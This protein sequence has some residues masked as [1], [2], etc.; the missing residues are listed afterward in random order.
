M[1]QSE[2]HHHNYSSPKATTL[3]NCRKYGFDSPDKSEESAFFQEESIYRQLLSEQS[4]IKKP[5]YIEESWLQGPEKQLRGLNQKPTGHPIRSDQLQH[6]AN[7]SASGCRNPVSCNPR[8][9]RRKINIVPSLKLYGF[10]SFALVI[11]LG[12][13]TKKVGQ[14]Y[15]IHRSLSVDGMTSDH[16][17]SSPQ[18]VDNHRLLTLRSFSPIYWLKEK[19]SRIHM[20]QKEEKISPR[21]TEELVIE[22]QRKSSI[23][24]KHHETNDLSS[25]ETPLTQCISWSIAALNLIRNMFLEHVINA[26]DSRVSDTGLP[27]N[28]WNYVL[29]LPMAKYPAGRPVDESLASQNIQNQQEWLSSLSRNEQI[30]KFFRAEFGKFIDIEFDAVWESINEKIVEKCSILDSSYIEDHPKAGSSADSSRLSNAERLVI[31]GM[32][33]ETINERLGDA[34]VQPDYALQSAGGRIIPELTSPEFQLPSSPTFWGRIGLARFI[35]PPSPFERSVEKAIQPEMDMGECWAMGGNHGQIGIRLARKIIVA[36]VT[37]EHVDPR[38]AFDLR[39]APREIEI[40]GLP[41]PLDS[42]QQVLFKRKDIN[43]ILFDQKKEASNSDAINTK[44]RKGKG[45]SST[46]ATLLGT[47]EYKIPEDKI[48]YPSRDDHYTRK[49]AKEPRIKTREGA[50]EFETTIE[51]ANTL[52]EI[53]QN[54]EIQQKLDQVSSAHEDVVSTISQLTER[55]SALEESNSLNEIPEPIVQ[56]EDEIMVDIVRE[57]GEIFALERL[58][59]EKR[60]LLH[61]MQKELDDLANFPEVEMMDQDKAAAEYDT[62]LES[63]T[64]A[65]RIEIEELDKRIQEQKD[66]EQQQLAAYEDLSRES[67]ELTAILNDAEANAEKNSSPNFDEMLRLW[68]RASEQDGDT[69]IDPKGTKEAYLKL[70][71]L[72]DGLERSQRLIVN[73]DVLQQMSTAIVDSY[74]DLTGPDFDPPRTTRGYLIA[75]TLQAVSVAGSISL[76]DLKDQISGEAVERGESADLGVQVVYL[77]VASYLMQIDRSK[78]P[79]MVSYT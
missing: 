7:N 34:T 38:V 21:V 27:G 28:P 36:E 45:S 26:Q 49:T 62:E 12:V 6:N 5:R 67:D 78:T 17:S 1:F 14:E 56:E 54:N 32:I 31:L 69:V 68:Q 51:L 25:K 63:E 24:Q 58:L 64:S 9:I 66:F 76:P 57:E 47:I 3:S 59:S 48:K 65:K 10:L 20:A 35:P 61:R 33:E 43:E 52:N 60:T 40:W 19:E 46:S 2:H 23:K 15:I 72:L 39:S 74:A 42:I 41:A 50:D 70:E 75:R 77:L 22:S 55:L 13:I 29:G 53:C 11:L 44:S 30:I 18:N 16:S 71:R 79:N 8:W 4:T 37:I 73:L